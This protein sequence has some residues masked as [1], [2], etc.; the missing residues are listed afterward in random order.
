VVGGFG[1]LLKLF[2]LGLKVLQMLFLALSECSLSSPV[3]SL[4]LLQN[5]VLDFT[6]MEI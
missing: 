5:N 3:L 4:A 1:G 6:I 2:N